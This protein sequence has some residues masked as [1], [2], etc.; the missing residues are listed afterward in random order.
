[1]LVHVG[2]GEGLQDQRRLGVLI[3]DV[4]QQAGRYIIHFSRLN[5]QEEKLQLGGLRRSLVE[6]QA[7]VQVSLCALEV[8]AQAGRPRRPEVDAGIPG[9]DGQAKVE[10]AAPSAKRRSCTA[11]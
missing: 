3:L 5:A 7:P 4:D 9:P 2:A 8:A 6:F 10:P 1:M 11:G